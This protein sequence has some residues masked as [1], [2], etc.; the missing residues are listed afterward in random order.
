MKFSILAPWTKKDDVA[1]LK[2]GATLRGWC[3]PTMARAI[4]ADEK[5]AE[6]LALFNSIKRLAEK[7]GGKAEST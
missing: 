6:A 2:L 5:E 3:L 1:K 7:Q 4:E